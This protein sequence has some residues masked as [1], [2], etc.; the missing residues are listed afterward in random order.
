MYGY[1]GKRVNVG[2][3]S[4]L[5]QPT[6]YTLIAFLGLWQLLSL[7][8]SPRDLP[9]LVHLAEITYSVVSGADQFSFVEHAWITTQRILV[10]FVFIMVIGTVLG[11]TMGVSKYKEFLTV[12][13]MIFLT[14][15]A[16]VWAFILVMWFGALTTYF[17]V[18][19]VTVLAV[20]PYVAVNIWKGA[21]SIDD[22]LLEMAHSFDLS[23]TA[24]WRH[25]FVPALMPF[26]YSSGRLAFALAW[27]LS[28]VAEIF[29]SSVGIGFVVHY[30]FGAVRADMIIAWSIP[31]MLAMF[32]IER[33]LKIVEKRSFAWRPE[34]DDVHSEVKT[35]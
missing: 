35:A 18:V 12:P 20:T 32:G 1:L 23:T 10:S 21:E 29:G 3:D 4:R 9:G 16:V 27:K 24:I 2:Y 6:L 5:Y 15:P 26:L 31:M 17:V 22:D 28:L 13:V 7:F 11:I 30:Y 8:F 19:T 25:I 33:A 14:F 34:V